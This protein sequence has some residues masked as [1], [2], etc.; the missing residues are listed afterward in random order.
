MSADSPMRHAAR[1]SPGDRV[2]LYMRSSP[3]HLLLQ[4]AIERAGLVQVPL[5]VRYTAM[6]VAS[7]LK[8]CE[9]AAIL[10]DRHGAAAVADRK[11]WQIAVVGPDFAELAASR[12]IGEDR[13][14]DLDRL[15]SIT[16]TSGTSG[17]PKGVKLSHRNWRAVTRNMLI[18]RRI[19]DGDRLAHTGP[20]TH[21]SGT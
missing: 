2:A 19:Q 9:A 7:L 18:D 17:R 5:N 3:E 4:M 1:L 13:S 20:Q 14:G 21:A 16:N 12:P 10:H 11:L 15:A 8:D 6:E